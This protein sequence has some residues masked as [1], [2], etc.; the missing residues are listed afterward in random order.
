MD[1]GALEIGLGFGP[2]PIKGTWFHRHNSFTRT[3][4]AEGV[5]GDTKVLHTA[6]IRQRHFQKGDHT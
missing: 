5:K 4:S 3:G 2:F 1:M 6:D